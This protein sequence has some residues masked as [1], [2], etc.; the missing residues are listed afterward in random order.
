M[1]K[2]LILSS[3]FPYPVDVGRKVI[4]SGILEY[5][6][7]AL[8]AENVTF[9]Y[10]ASPSDIGEDRTAPCRV[11][12]LPLDGLGRRLGGAAWQGGIRRRRALQEMMLY[13]RHAS[14]RLR[15]L[16][17]TVCP[18]L[19]VVD[20]VRMAQYAEACAVGRPQSVLYLDDLY[21]LRYRRMIEAMRAY[22]EAALDPLGT[23]GRFLPAFARDLIQARLFQ[24]CLLALES[25]ILERRE[26]ELPYRFDS[27]LL[28]NEAEACTLAARSDAINVKTIKPLLRVHC[29]RLPRR[30]EG[31]PTYLF[32]GNLRYPANACSL[33][34]FL[35]QAMPAL[36]RAEPRAKLL[37]VGRG[38]DERLREQCARLVGHVELM[39]FVEDLAP[40]MATAAAMIVPLIYGSGVKM[41]VLDGLY[42]G[43]P[44]VSTPSG[45][46]GVTAVD[47]SECFIAKDMPSFVEPL[48]RLCDIDLNERVSA[49]ARGLYAKEFAPE[50]VLGQYAEIFGVSTRAIEPAFAS[51]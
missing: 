31:A 18:D 36:L 23:F 21:S 1:M 30:F 29:H 20:T 49:N 27:V 50:V 46:D 15:D 28:L 8:G 37:V 44:I 22:P 3:S 45:I 32:L 43:L 13:S 9:A 4:I 24:K 48:L 51:R 41:K 5:L 6:V 25:G 2:A 42:Y 12:V 47:G 7:S 26:A 16:M 40:L 39:D 11:V 10:I 19:V 17:R 33:S 34:L 35:S 14:A 38:A